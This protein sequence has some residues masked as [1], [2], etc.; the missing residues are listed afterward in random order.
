M[1]ASSKTLVLF[2]AAGWFGLAAAFASDG[3]WKFDI[4]ERGHPEL[5][6][7]QNDKTIFYVGCGHAFGLHAVYPGAPKKAGE[8]A[9]ITISNGHARMEFDGEIDDSHEDDPPNTT[10][11]LQWDLGF[12]RQDP[13][14]YGRRWKRLEYRFLDVLDSGRPLTISAE[15]K[16]YVLPAVDAK[17]WKKR[18]KDRC[19]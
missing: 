19:A 13:A 16:S 12:R 6:Y 10:H 8:K 2:V 15:K 17:D 18:F 5:R 9:A 11:F 4:E 14:L 1:L 7:A 3:S